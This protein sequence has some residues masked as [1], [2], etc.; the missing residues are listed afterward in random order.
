MSLCPWWASY[1]HDFSPKHQK[2]SDF[3]G[4]WRCYSQ[5]R[6]HT[7]N[8]NTTAQA[9]PFLGS[10]NYTEHPFGTHTIPEPIPGACNPV[11]GHPRHRGNLC[12]QSCLCTCKVSSKCGKRG[13]CLFWGI[14]RHKLFCTCYKNHEWDCSFAIGGSS[15]APLCTCRANTSCHS[16]TPT[17]HMYSSSKCCPNTHPLILPALL[18]SRH[19]CY[20]QITDWEAKGWSW[21]LEYSRGSKGT[22]GSI[23]LSQIPRYLC[24]QTQGCKHHTWEWAAPSLSLVLRT[25]P[26]SPLHNIKLQKITQT[27]A[28][29][30]QTQQGCKIKQPDTC[31]NSYQ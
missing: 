5:L 14:L 15:H 6:H 26:L 10:K 7:L 22:K 11:E 27:Q 28:S 18:R 16:A 4:S 13:T 20:P 31:L 29:A 24:M 19:L 23:Q 8:S 30:G 2:H 25:K 3:L 9:L 1:L 21:R 17:A 12:E